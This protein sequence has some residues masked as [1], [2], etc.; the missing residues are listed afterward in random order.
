VRFG[1]FAPYLLHLHGVGARLSQ[2]RPF[3]INSGTIGDNPYKPFTRQYGLE[4][5]QYYRG[6]NVYTDVEGNEVSGP[7]VGISWRALDHGRLIGHYQLLKTEKGSSTL[8]ETR[9]AVVIE[10]NFMF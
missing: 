10:A 5:S 1:Q 4:L 2:D 7:L 9:H 3:V 6:F 8:D